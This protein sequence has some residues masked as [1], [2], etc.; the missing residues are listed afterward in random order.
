M[1]RVDRILLEEI[2]A[3]VEAGEKITAIAH[4]LGVKR[5]A[6]YNALRRLK[7][8]LPEKEDHVA[9]QQKSGLPPELYAYRAGISA[10]SL[11][12]MAHQR[13][14]KLT[15]SKDAERKAFWA[16]A[17]ATFDGVNVRAFCQAQDLPLVRV[18]YWYH[19]IHKPQ[20]A[21]LWGF[22]RIVEIPAESFDLAPAA[23]DP[24]ALF[25]LGRG[26][27]VRTT[28]SAEANRLYREHTA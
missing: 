2:C 20:K 16:Q 22:N 24:E 26:R 28:S 1:P 14:E 13:G 4:S 21:L 18:A 3:R 27:E 19:R 7:M 23:F 11:R 15:N 9:L 5:H 12:V 17:I 6:I 25:V 8:Q 10:E